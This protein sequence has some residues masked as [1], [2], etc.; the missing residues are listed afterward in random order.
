MGSAAVGV[1]GP[2]AWLEPFLEVLGRKTRR[3]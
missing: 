3:N 2:D 1:R